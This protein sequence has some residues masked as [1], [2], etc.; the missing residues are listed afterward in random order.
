MSD[1]MTTVIHWGQAILGV[2]VVFCLVAAIT[3]LLN[4]K[5]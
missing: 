3:C 5:R 2:G 1:E 4:V